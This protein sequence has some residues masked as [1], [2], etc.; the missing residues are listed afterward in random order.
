MVTAKEL[1][2]RIKWDKNLK[3]EEYFIFYIDRVANKLAVI[4]YSDI[5]KIDGSFMV[6]DKYPEEVYIPLHRI[7]EIRRD[8]KLVWRRIV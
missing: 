3:P 2:S 6:L 5:L 1:L 7:R 4:K 8:G